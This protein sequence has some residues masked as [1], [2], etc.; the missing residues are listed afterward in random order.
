MELATLNE[1]EK[2]PH[3]VLTDLLHTRPQTA[4]LDILTDIITRGTDADEQLAALISAAWER[5]CIDNLWSYRFENV[6]QYREAINYAGQV[7]PVILRHKKSDQAKRFSNELIL[8]SWGRATQ[9]LLPE[10]LRPPF[11]SKH[12]LTLVATLSKHCPLPEALAHLEDGIHNRPPKSRNKPYLLASDVQR[13]LRQ[14]G[15]PPRRHSQGRRQARINIEG[16][17][18]PQQSSSGEDIMSSSVQGPG[19]PGIDI[20]DPPTRTDTGQDA[21]LLQGLG[22]IVPAEGQLPISACCCAPIGLPLATLLSQPQVEISRECARSLLEWARTISWSCFCTKHLNDLARIIPGLDIYRL[23]QIDIITL[24]ED[25]FASSDCDSTSGPSQPGQYRCIPPAHNLLNNYQTDSRDIQFV[26]PIDHQAL[27]ERFTGTPGVWKDW[28]EHGLL[29]IPGFF[30]YMEDFGVFARVKTVTELLAS[31]ELGFDE[32]R[33]KAAS[34]Q[35]YN[36]LGQMVQQDPSYYA[37]VVACRG[38]N[39]WRLVHRLSHQPP[40]GLFQPGDIA[41]GVGLDRLPAL[42][43]NNG[44][45]DVQSTIVFPRAETAPQELRIV[46]GFQSHLKE[47]ISAKTNCAYFNGS[48]VI[49]SMSYDENDENRFGHSRNLSVQPGDLLLSLPHLVRWP[50]TFAQPNLYHLSQSGLDDNFCTL[51]N[52]QGG[53]WSRLSIINNSSQLRSLYLNPNS[54]YGLG[55]FNLDV[56]AINYHLGGTTALGDALLGRREWK[57]PKALHECNILLGTDNASAQAFV[58]RARERLVAEFQEAM[59]ILELSLYQGKFF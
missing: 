45:S 7:R 1:F 57:D 14:F 24:L 36:L 35:C 12:L 43:H 18:S 11:W 55:G 20:D 17:V 46:P 40:S 28:N 37:I 29:H 30:Q 3:Q 31:P 56:D 50:H 8:R 22:A 4:H 58:Q 27:L 23:A 13:V 49:T 5:V 51:E 25:A 2:D 47:W 34:Q 16:S 39:N 41:L 15:L 26:L 33:A 54:E 9:D 52:G 6:S 48:G 59:D 42:L 32:G 10:D 21:L 38:D 53:T 44:S 19:T